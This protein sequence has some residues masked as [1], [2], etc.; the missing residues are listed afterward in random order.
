M[1][2][3]LFALITFAAWAYE[4]AVIDSDRTSQHK[5]YCEMDSKGKYKTKAPKGYVETSLVL[6]TLMNTV[7]V[8]LLATDIHILTV[9]R[10]LD[11]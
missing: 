3:H 4:I 8:Y 1:S 5:M 6:M 9:K 7:E 11:Y 2:V 10:V